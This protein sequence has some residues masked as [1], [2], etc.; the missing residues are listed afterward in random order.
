LS[1]ILRI[2]GTAAF[3]LAFAVKLK[4]A[5]GMLDGR[6]L[7]IVA[8][9]ELSEA[10]RSRL[11][12]LAITLYGAA[13]S[14][15]SYAFLKTVGAAEAEARRA[16]AMS[17]HIDESQLSP[18]LIREKALPLFASFVEDVSIRQELLRMP[19]LS[20]FYGYM[21]QSLVV[22]LVLVV[23][24][25]TMAADI[26]SGTA[27]YALFRCD[28]LT[29]AT[30]KLLGQEA[31]LASGLIV[32]A[33]LAGAVGQTLDSAFQTETWFWLFRT[34]FRAWLYANAYL[35]LFMGL[36]LIASTQLK[37]RALSLFSW[38]GLGIAH[39]I[40]TADFANR[41]VPWLQHLAFLFPA[42][43]RA[44][45]WSPDWS[46]YLPAS[47]ALILFGFLGFAMGNRVFQWRDA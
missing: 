47:L 8:R 6:K 40:V 30:G 17:L 9:F 28:R 45:L 22:L 29:W 26:S 42:A 43:H 16:L 27:R 7:W 15:G 35:G 2:G 4:Q 41:R 19:P 1:I 44:S 14:L 20:I 36:S 12:V 37:A 13:A 32:G 46:V 23:S 39:S 25:G 11:F 18:D 10:I 33:L 3:S 24:A 21:A 31:V 34:S 38:M 5:G